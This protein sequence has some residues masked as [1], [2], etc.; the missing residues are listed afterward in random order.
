VDRK[1]RVVHYINQFFAGIGAEDKAHVGPQ[2]KEG[3]IGPGRA[4]QAALKDRGDVV[5]TIFCGDNYFTERVEESSQALLDMISPYKPDIVFAGPAFNAGRY[6]IACGAMCKAV[7]EKMGIP[8]I[9]GMFEEAPGVDIYRRYIYIV[10]TGDNART[11]GETINKMVS[12]GL[13]IVNKEELGTPEEEGY[14]AKGLLK[15]IVSEN[16]AAQRAVRMMLNKIKGEP[17]IT[18]LHL[19]KFEHT[20]PAPALK[21]ISGARIAIVTDGGLV[22]KGNPDKLQSEGALKYCRYSIKGINALKAGEYDVAHVGYDGTAVRDNPN[23]LV[24]V[25]VMRDVE[26][27]KIIG[28]LDDYFYTTAGVATTLPNSKKFGQA[29]AQ[30]LKSEGVEAA[31][32]TST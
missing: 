2:V 5:A 21:N 6:S 13:K 7:E 14:I 10:K 31:I 4:L 17:F 29:I 32:L 1:L 26:K 27:E 28:Y 22:P 11:M 16:T 8:A 9:T 19:P 3:S 23:R 20:K 18:E 24:P 30:Q 15:M 25:D 12:L